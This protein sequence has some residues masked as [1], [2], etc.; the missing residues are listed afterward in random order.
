M[1]DPRMPALLVS[2]HRPGFYFRVLREGAVRPGDPIV[3]VAAGP[4]AMTVAEVD[5]LLTC[6][7]IRISGL[8][9][10]CAFPLSRKAG[11]RSSARFS[12]NPTA[13]AQG[14]PG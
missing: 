3:K 13:P 8:R 4:E 1:N 12:S 14:M 6:P 7:A 10:R 9:P 2:H 5:G 11:R